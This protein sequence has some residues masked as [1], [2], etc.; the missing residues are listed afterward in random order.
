MNTVLLPAELE[1]A[2]RELEASPDYRVLRRLVPRNIVHRPLRAG[3]RTAVV[4]DVE[5]TGLDAAVDE[6]IELGMV[7]LAYDRNDR[8]TDV[9]GDFSSFN[10]PSRKI[11]ADVSEM[12][13][14][15]DAM[16]KGH[17]IDA[18]AV[19]RFVADAGILLA[20]NAVF[21]RAF[22]THL[23]PVFET[24][25]WSCTATEIEWKARR[26]TSKPSAHRVSSTSTTLA[27]RRAR[28]GTRGGPSRSFPTSRRSS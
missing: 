8:I 18:S 6:V 17:R 16:V 14:I 2:A 21:D 23:S 1:T 4:L 5:T 19:E 11:P 10:E 15:T 9:I 28:A 12:T 25:A 7:A 13:G 22:V 27:P 26:S 3:E 24:K 20:H